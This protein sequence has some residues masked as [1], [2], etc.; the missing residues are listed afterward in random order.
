MKIV[1]YGVETVNKGAELMLYAILQEIERVHPEAVI[2]M[3]ESRMPQGKDY[4]KTSLKIKYWPLEYI[5]DKLHLLGIF[6]HLNLPSSWLVNPFV[7]KGTNYFL[8]GSGFRFS[9]QFVKI[10]E[11]SGW[12]KRTLQVLSK[13]RAKIVFLPQ[14]F[15]P[16]KH[17]NTIDALSAL[18]KYSSI[19]MTREEVSY[20][21]LRDSGVVDMKKVKLYPDF[22]SLVKGE[23]PKK[24]IHLRNGICVIPNIR[25]ISSG[26]ISYDDYVSLIL[27]I[28]EEG[29]KCG[30]LV[31]LL[32]H[33]GIEDEQLAFK[34]CESAKK[35]IEVVTGIN[36]LEVK[37]L[38][39]GRAHV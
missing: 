10:G 12:W 21:Y 5:I 25:M 36:A 23:F 13:E 24:Y 15:G 14:A 18:S 6:R 16:V 19:I 2:Y 9:D 20:N 28:I 29:K 7:F 3:P 33:E 27:S 22:T 1:L 8:D 39:I 30:R 11:R 31:Y 35:Q 37:G 17:R 32:N 34:C 26:T 4:V 38:K